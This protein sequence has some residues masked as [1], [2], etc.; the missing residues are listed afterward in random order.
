VSKAVKEA[1]DRRVEVKKAWRE[2][3]LTPAGK[4][5]LKDI[6]RTFSPPS[7][8]KKINGVVDPYA[9]LS[10]NGAFEVISYIRSMIDE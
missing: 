5:A 8:I 10:A 4:A 2:W 3:S 6:E 1:Q 7:L 9:T